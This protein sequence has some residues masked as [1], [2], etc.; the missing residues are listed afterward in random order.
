M[1]LSWET[2]NK[3]EAK[4]G[5][6]FY[7][8]DL[9]KFQDNYLKFL[10]AF[11]EIHP[12]THIAYSYKTNY[13]PKLCR[14]VNQMGGYAEVVSR[15]EYD[16]AVRIGVAPS[17]IIFNGPYKPFE[18][19]QTALLAGAVVNLDSAYELES[20]EQIARQFPQYRLR[21]GVRCNLD[22]SDFA[23]SRFGFDVTRLGQVFNALSALE[24]CTV[25]GLHCHLLPPR[26]NT[27]DYALITR[28]MLLLAKT[29]FKSPPRFIDL[30]GGF[31]SPMSADL[32]KQ[33]NLTIPSYQQYAAAIANQFTLAYPG[34]DGP[35][36]ILEPGMAITA[37]I[38]QFVTKVID[39]KTIK[40]RTVALV[41]GSIYNVKPTLSPKNLPIQIHHPPGEPLPNPKVL[42]TTDIVGYTCME[43]DILYT[44][45]SQ[46]LAKHDYVVFNSVGAYTNVLKPPFINPSP[47]II[48]LNPATGEFEIIKRAE[49]TA[50]IFATYQF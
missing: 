29:H 14:L 45:L 33:F 44:G 10:N 46:P 43:N 32:Q 31:F 7:L 30:G 5:T 27:E 24:N 25:E 36:L 6:S 23:V 47:A 38:M 26:R 42:P 8:L 18:D 1:N 3:L 34:N 19:I 2:L 49:E 39:I 9:L 40:T 48:A 4:W 20:V 21:V 17:N 37:D 15:M 11:K 35:Q 50:D 16:L 28:Q 41:S 22:L 12:H 13:I